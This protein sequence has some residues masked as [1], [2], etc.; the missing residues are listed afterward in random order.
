[1]RRFGKVVDDESQPGVASGELGHVAEVIGKDGRQ[2]EQQPALLEQAERR[3]DVAAQ[4]PVRVGLLVDEM[5]DSAQLRPTSQVVEPA[6]CD[7]DVVEP[8]PRRD[9][10][11]PLRL[12][13][14]V[15]HVVGVLVARRTL[16]EHRRSDAA[17]CEQRLEVAW[18]ERPIDH[19]VLLRHPRL[20][21]ERGVPKVM[22]GIDDHA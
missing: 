16:D 11:D 3:L 7:S 9:G 20:R 4:E 15:E 5:A 19:L 6:A 14:Q 8:A 2:L 17:L 22:V 21:D 10:A 13:D 1:M 12:L 18:L